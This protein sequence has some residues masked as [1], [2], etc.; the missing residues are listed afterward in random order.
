MQGGELPGQIP[1]L[2]RSRLIKRADLLFQQRQEVHRIEDHVRFFVGPLVAGDDFRAAADD[3][4]VDIAA[5]LDL[6]MGL[7][8]PSGGF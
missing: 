3:D 6:V 5:N 2:Q 1:A 4:L 7:P 8:A